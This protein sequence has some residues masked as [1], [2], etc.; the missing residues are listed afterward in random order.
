MDLFATI[1]TVSIV[2]F[3]VG[4]F[5]LLIELFVPGFGI[6]GGLGIVA[7]I[8]CIVFQA[9]SVAEGL[10]LFLIMAAIVMIL[11]LIAARSLKRGW[12]YRSSLVLKDAEEKEAG[13]VARDDYS[14]FTGKNGVSLTPLRPAGS[15]EIDGEKADVVTEGDYIP[16]DARIQVLKTVGGRII[17]KQL[18]G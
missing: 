4:L 14:R 17:V 5:F 16:K 13:Y 9:H 15:A 10:V 3:A 18:E 12:L 11:A 2:L 7:L 6:F 8:L 1:E